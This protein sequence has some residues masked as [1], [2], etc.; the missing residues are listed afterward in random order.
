MTAPSTT[1]A[2]ELLRARVRGEVSDSARRRAEY[3]T[4]A[5]N[6]RVLP[7]VVVFPLDVDDLVAV[8]DVAREHRIPLTLRGGGTSV[9]GNSIGEGI[10]VDVS[11]RNPPLPDD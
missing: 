11:W 5:S 10:V 7:A 1:D 4:D 2:A 8:L 9:A 6:Y 3:A